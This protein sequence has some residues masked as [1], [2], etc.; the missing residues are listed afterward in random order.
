MF[1]ASTNP[2]KDNCCHISQTCPG[3]LFM[4]CGLACML[5]WEHLGPT[6]CQW[7]ALAGRD[8]Q[9]HSAQVL[10][11]CC[12]EMEVLYSH[13]VLFLPCCHLILLTP[14]C[15]QCYAVE[16]EN[17]NT[18]PQAYHVSRHE[19]VRASPRNLCFLSCL[20]VNF[21]VL[22][23]FVMFFFVL[24]QT[25][26]IFNTKHTVYSWPQKQLN[27][28]R[29]RSIYSLVLELSTVYNAVFISR[30]SFAICYGTQDVQTFFTFITTERTQSADED[31]GIR[32][33]APERS[34]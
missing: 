26:Q 13:P 16:H 2:Q 20:R 18:L 8:L 3:T 15:T 19:L 11:W 7:V 6:Y 33:K 28:F 5:Y 14:F 10:S 24:P 29:L 27:I 22:F 31:Y 1:R 12:G 32:S 23:S 4:D 21:D 9:R 34:V 17:K 30:L 25:T